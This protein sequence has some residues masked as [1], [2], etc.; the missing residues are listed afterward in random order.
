MYSFEVVNYHECNE[1]INKN[2]EDRMIFQTEQWLDFVN[3]CKQA[4]PVVI[5]ILR[6]GKEIG[7]YTCMLFKIFGIRFAG[8]PFRGWTTLYMGFNLCPNESRTAIIPE[9]WRFMRKTFGCFY[10]EIVDWKISVEEAQKAGLPFGIQETYVKEITDDINQV[11]KTFSSTCRNQIRRFERNEAKLQTVDP[12]EAFAEE[13]YLELEK[14]F[15]YQGLQPSYDL[16]RVKSLLKHIR[17]ISDNTVYTTV[18]YS[19]DGTPIGTLIGF[20][21]RKTAY[22]WGLTVIREEQYYQS[23]ALL[24][25]SFLHWKA[26]GYEHYDLVGV[27]PYKLKFHPELCQTPRITCCS[28]P[29]MIKLRDLAEKLYWVFNKIKSRKKV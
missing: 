8:S 13:Y 2:Y 18:S 26:L 19:P 11:F 3:E 1:Y 9:L 21:F 23:D 4:E 14:V 16:K 29:F 15:A 6:E 25:D 5:R 22:L 7:Y 20:G 24:W 28:I 27:R 10:M 12:D 17:E